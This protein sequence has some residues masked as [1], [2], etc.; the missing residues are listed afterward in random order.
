MKQSDMCYLGDMEEAKCHVQIGG[1]DSWADVQPVKSF[2]NQDPPKNQ[3]GTC[4]LAAIDEAVTC[5]IRRI[6]LKQSD[7]CYLADM[8]EAKCY[9]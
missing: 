5:A 3:S 9:V 6:W 4:K 8:E 7:M 1:C 2:L